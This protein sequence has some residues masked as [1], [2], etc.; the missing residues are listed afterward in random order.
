MQIYPKASNRTATNISGGKKI[1]KLIFRLICYL[2]KY[3]RVSCE[4]S[5]VYIYESVWVWA[6][7]QILMLGIELRIKMKVEGSRKMLKDYSLLTNQINPI[8]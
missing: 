1:Q 5:L 6:R 3:V 2:S 8:H 4:N 7:E